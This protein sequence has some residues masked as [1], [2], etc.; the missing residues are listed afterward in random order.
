MTI[1]ALDP[2]D[3]EVLHRRLVHGATA[4]G[5][6][7]VAYREIESPIGT[8]LLASTARGLVRVAFAAEGI[9]EVLETLGQRLSPR[10]LR[11][12]TRLDR[13]ATQLDEYFRGAR[14]AFDLDLDDALSTGFR[15]HVQ[16]HLIDIPYGATASYGQVAAALG[17]PKAVR[18]VGTACATNPLPIVQPCHRVLRADGSLGGY[19]G[20]PAAKSALLR[21]ERG[22]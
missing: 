17:N 14:T 9:E 21:L 11:A 16:A 15:A 19:L 10:I 20:G 6:L 3:L 1:P 18:A 22:E 12:P 2:A 5:L 13:A 8:L 7:D 4:A